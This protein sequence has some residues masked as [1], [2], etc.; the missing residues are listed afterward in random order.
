MFYT[1]VCKIAFFSSFT[2]KNPVI[3]WFSMFLLQHLC[4]ICITFQSDLYQKTKDRKMKISDNKAMKTRILV[5][6]LLIILA[7]FIVAGASNSRI[8]NARPEN[9]SMNSADQELEIEAWMISDFYWNSVNHSS[10]ER[11]WDHAL[12]LED[13]MTSVEGWE[14]D[15]LIPVD[16]EV[17]LRIEP[18]MKDESAWFV[19]SKRI[20]RETGDFADWKQMTGTGCRDLE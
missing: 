18:W 11:V 15:M 1:K 10:L 7:S 5:S 9:I 17:S 6:T 4:N 16:R 13:W 20:V 8:K 2:G 3:R 12:V 19:C 14:T